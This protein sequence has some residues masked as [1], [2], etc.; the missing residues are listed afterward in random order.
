MNARVHLNTKRR[1]VAHA[2]M[3]DLPPLPL[4]ASSLSTSHLLACQCPVWRWCTA[5][6]HPAR[7]WLW[8]VTRDRR[9]DEHDAAAR[10]TEIAGWLTERER[11]CTARVRPGLL[12][13]MNMENT[14]VPSARRKRMINATTERKTRMKYRADS[15]TT[16]RRSRGRP[17]WN[18]TQGNLNYEETHK[19]ITVKSASYVSHFVNRAASTPP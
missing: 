11:I 4:D 19:L 13:N 1:R 14:I 12:L 8:F 2:T 18:C 16:K 6:L 10:I 3:H 7:R 5:R 15:C 9:M 17:L